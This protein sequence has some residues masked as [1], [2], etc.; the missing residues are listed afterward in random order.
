MPNNA[1]VKVQNNK[2]QRNKFRRNR[3]KK[4]NNKR[5]NKKNRYKKAILI[6]TAVSPRPIDRALR[7]EPIR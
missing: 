4:F 5:N 3:N 2:I 1:Q 7:I 6:L